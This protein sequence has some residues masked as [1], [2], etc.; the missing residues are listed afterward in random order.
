MKSLA[1]T[2]HAFLA[3]LTFCASLAVQ[4]AP[5]MELLREFAVPQANQ[6]VGA[7]AHHFYA[8]DNQ[9]IAKYD[10]LTGKLV[11]QWRGDKKGPILHLDSALLMDGKIYAAHSNYPDW[12]MTSSLEIFD[13]DTM[14]HIGSRSFGIQ[15]GS[16]TWVDWHDGHWWMVFANYDVPLGPNKT[17]YGHKANTLMV[18]FTRDFQPVQSWTL[19]KALLERF[20]LMSNS[21]GSWGA[22]GYLYLSGHDPAEIYRMRLP[23]A[24]SVLELVEVLPMTIRGQGIAWDRSQPDVMYGIVRATRKELEAGGSHKV[25]VSRLKP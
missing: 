7:D 24:G 18:K 1:T 22:D 25:T 5:T 17:P 23:K 6:G 19:P 15:Y 11:K 4:A 13:A 14:E 9:T 12:P 10:K 8:V 16:M 21:G 2:A 3:V 20:E